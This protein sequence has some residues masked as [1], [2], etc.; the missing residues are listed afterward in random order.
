VV[1]GLERDVELCPLEAWADV[2]EDAEGVVE[3]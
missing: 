2:V 1:V 3:H